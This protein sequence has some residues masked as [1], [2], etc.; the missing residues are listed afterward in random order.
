M[1]I[2]CLFMCHNNKFMEFLYING[3][4]N[5][6]SMPFQPTLGF[7]MVPYETNFPDAKNFTIGPMQSK[8]WP[9]IEKFS[10]Y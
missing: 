6:L 1:H 7:S 10:K 4:R 8:A 2:A 5:L 3:Q 9:C